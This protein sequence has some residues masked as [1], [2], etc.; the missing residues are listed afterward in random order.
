MGTGR[1]V[2]NLSGVALLN[3]LWL[4]ASPPAIPAADASK[5]V[6]EGDQVSPFR[7][8]GAASL[9]FRAE[10]DLPEVEGKKS[11]PKQNEICLGQTL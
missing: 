9:G 5:Q 2:L 11:A 6:D 3:I 10:K 8:I 1:T 4:M 7:E